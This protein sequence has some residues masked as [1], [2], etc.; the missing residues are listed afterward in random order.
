M[1]LCR[2]SLYAI[3]SDWCIRV[4]SERERSAWQYNERLIDMDNNNYRA[5]ALYAVR[6]ARR[7]SAA[8]TLL[9]IVTLAP[10]GQAWSTEEEGFL[11]LSLDEL[12]NA[13]VSTASKFAQKTNDAPAA[14][15]IIT[16]DE[17]EL[18]G[19]ET[20]GELLG[21]VRGMYAT[22]DRNYEYLGIR[23]IGRTSNFNNRFL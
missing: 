4:A 14:V 5:Q 22:Y 13:T 20:L 21:S 11:D 9:L 2:A 23:G 18:Y 7:L 6:A 10:S 16:A 12:V 17:I 1:A 19:Y 3:R 8:T 15:S